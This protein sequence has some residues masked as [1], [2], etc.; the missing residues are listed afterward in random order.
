MKLAGANPEPPYFLMTISIK[1][2]PRS[3]DDRLEYES[4]VAIVRVR[5]A[6]VDGKANEAVIRLLAN[7]LGIPKSHIEIVGGHTS[8]FKKIN[9]PE[10]AAKKLSEGMRNSRG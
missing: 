4:G 5:A 2:K 10:G 8:R 1:V 9:M 6:A 3:R 7:E